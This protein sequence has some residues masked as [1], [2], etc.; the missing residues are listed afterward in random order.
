MI[1]DRTGQANFGTNT[2][3]LD[4][5]LSQLEAGR[6]LTFHIGFDANLGPGSYSI[7]LALH[8]QDTHLH[9][10]YEWRDL[11]VVFTVINT[12]K[13]VFVGS[14]WLPVSLRIDP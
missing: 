8:D 12:S 9:Q 10:N 2:F 3:H 1:K 14:N 4:Q 6:Q 7:A 13:P 11:A 5:P